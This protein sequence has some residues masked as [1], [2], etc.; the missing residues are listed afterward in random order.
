M[1]TLGPSTQLVSWPPF[2]TSGGKPLLK[3]V[4]GN[5][6]EG[7]VSDARSIASKVLS[8]RVPLRL[9]YRDSVISFLKYWLRLAVIQKNFEVF[10]F[11]SQSCFG[12]VFF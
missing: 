1:A 6:I 12:I 8:I 11:F 4:S 3:L 10:V 9:V 5:V 7:V 2:P